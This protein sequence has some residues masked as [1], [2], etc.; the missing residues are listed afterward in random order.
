M[1]NRQ[2][3]YVRSVSLH[4]VGIILVAMMCGSSVLEYTHIPD[5]RS[6]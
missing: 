2:C 1:E 4:S 5:S 3:M 6:K